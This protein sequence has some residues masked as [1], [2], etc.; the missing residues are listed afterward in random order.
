MKTPRCAHCGMPSATD[1]CDACY[2]RMLKEIE[3]AREYTKCE[4]CGADLFVGREDD[5][6]CGD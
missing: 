1:E 5:H 3:D 2:L 6:H 4:G